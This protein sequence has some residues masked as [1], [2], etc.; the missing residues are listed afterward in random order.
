MKARRISVN[1]RQRRLRAVLVALAGILGADALQAGTTW[2]GGGG[3]DTTITNDLNWGGTVNALNGTQPAIFASGGTNATLNVNARFKTL[4]FNQPGGFTINGPGT[5]TVS[6]STSSATINF[7]VAAAQGDGATVIDT[8]MFVETGSAG[9]KLLVLDNSDP[10]STTGPSLVFAN[11]LTATVPANTW[12]FRLRGSGTTRFAGAV[13]NCTAIQ[14][15]LA[16]YTG[17]NIFAGN[18]ALGASTDVAIQAPSTSGSSATAR[19][20]M[21]ETLNDIQSWRSTLVQQSGTVAIHA[22]AT[23]S[24]GVSI[25]T[26]GASGGVLEVNGSLSATTLGLGSGSLTGTLKLGGV[27]SFSGAA[28]IGAAYGSM[29]VGNSPSGGTLVLSSGAIPPSV[30]VG[31]YNPN[32]DNLT[33]VK[34]NLG[35]L[36]LD[37]YQVY[38]NAT[39]V[40]AGRLDLL[41]NIPSPV[42][43]FDGASL[44][45]EGTTTRS[46]TFGAG[47]TSLYFDPTT[48][49]MLTADSINA[50]AGVVI[51]SPTAP[52]DGVV[53]QSATPIVGTIGVN[54]ILASRAGTLSFAAGGTQLY[55]TSGAAAAAD[56]RW[57]G[58]AA[59]PTFW[60]VIVTA[61]WTNGA[62]ADVFYSGDNVQFDDSASSTSVAIQGASAVPGSTT[63]SNH[64]KPYTFSGGAI[65]GAGRLTKSG[66]GLVDI[67]SSGHSFAGG[68]TINGGLLNLMSPAA[69]SFTGGVTN[70]GGTLV[71]SNLNQVGS[72]TSSSLN[73]INL[74]GGTLSYTGPTF[75]QGTDT[76]TLN[77]LGGV[78]TIEITGTNAVT[79]RAGAPVTGP[80]DLI[81]SGPGTLALGRNSYTG[82]LG[83]TFTGKI[84]VTAG[85]LDIRQPDS[86][87][88][89][90]GITE[91]ANATLYLDPFGQGAGVEFS[92]EPLV[93]SGESYIRNY[94]QST[95][96][97][98]VDVLTGPITNRGTLGIYCQTNGGYGE[99]QITGPIVTSAGSVLA[100]GK[101]GPGIIGVTTNGQII[102]ASGL[103]TGPASVSAQGNAASTYTLANHAYTGNT[104]VKGGKLVLQE[105]TLA[106]DS[107]V[108]ISNLAVLQLDFAVTNTVKNLIVNGVG[109]APGIYSSANLAPQ[110][111][112]IGSL[113]VT[114]LPVAT[115]S[116]NLTFTVSG[117]TLTLSWPAT[118]QGWYAQSNS[119]SVAS[120]SDWHDLPGSQT[121]TSVN[122]TINP[123][124]TNVFYRL[125]QP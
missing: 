86:L 100:F 4:T 20:Q 44:G 9:T 27:A 8:K 57:T 82:P 105:A 37:G 121:G 49:G 12:A 78:S 80:G 75:S 62:H 118:H 22:K 59:N 94:N 35:T 63:I 74:N 51:V 125:R 90:A 89:V 23:Q 28:T 13:S 119:L 18:Q 101:P 19:I 65:G 48:P 55:F 53:L 7:S 110:L 109:Q 47:N 71:F 34:T 116:T 16:T 52:G 124:L 5:L 96:V 95:T 2:D 24:G 83:N 54:F 15:A 103:I 93:F 113:Q 104:T 33:L 81:K 123:A 31:G 25:A 42:T 76:F 114:A 106:A 84:T 61:N 43:V 14:P 45:G 60:D 85:Q 41:G 120:S 98:Q 30:T 112:G 68:L 72:T 67:L 38:T 122:I 17:T 115:Y 64:T 88:D 91:L 39:L 6:N 58:V 107:V 26:A 87:G 117:S 70:N 66:A 32:E 11:T 73:A 29:I 46:L 111:A 36:T 56:L 99:L 97:A 69:N 102:T 108:S 77:L 92:A 1:Y 79:L 3:T 50:S 40:K 10:M 21:G